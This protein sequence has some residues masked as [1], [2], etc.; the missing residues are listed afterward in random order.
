M[1]L[2]NKLYNLL[3][4]LLFIV[5]CLAIRCKDLHY[6]ILDIK[7][8]NTFAIDLNHNGVIDS[9]EWLV[10]KDLRVVAAGSVSEK[11]EFI[12]NQLALNFAKEYFFNQKV[13]YKNG[14]LLVNGRSY[15]AAF[16]S[17]GYN[18]DLSLEKAKDLLNY[19]RT[20]T[21]YVVNMHNYRYH[22]Y[23]CKH[24]LRAEKFLVFEQSNLPLKSVPC[25][26]CNKEL[27]KKSGGIKKTKKN[28]G[29]K[30]LLTDLTSRLVP[31]KDCSSNI[32][33][34]LLYRINSAKVSI[35]FAIYGYSEVPELER[36]IEA[37]KNR[38]VKI[39][40]V[41]D[42]DSNNKTDYAE[43]E[44]LANLVGSAMNDYHQESVKNKY[45]NSL[46]HNK[47]YIF[48]NSSV[49]MGSAN[50]SGT[51]MSG[52]NS[53]SV[54]VIDSPRV[55]NIY[56]TEFEKMY[57][58]NFHNLKSI[59]QNNKNI[60]VD[61]NVLSVYFSPQDRITKNYIIPLI[62]KSKKSIFVP[63]FLITDKWLADELIAAN[64]RGVEVRV[65]LDALSSNSP[66]SQIHRLR[67]SGVQVK[68]ENYAGKIHSKSIIIDDEIV[69]LGSMNFSMSGQN[70]NDEN[71]VIIKH[72]KM[73]QEYRKFFDYLWEK[74]DERWLSSIP[75]AE[76]VDSIG[77]CSDGIDNNYDGNIDEDDVGCQET[78]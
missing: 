54:L 34:E 27:K 61:E 25:S 66:Y 52:F 78:P 63:A 46:M 39:R 16:N 57:F 19:I 3:A 75:R 4:V 48:D 7:S 51:D 31:T 41:Y 17:A 38:G 18:A 9:D 28:E 71:V 10:L 65:I 11:E 40:M 42:V 2:A 12:L 60:K 49:V 13:R 62:K 72:P 14:D 53:N 30:L 67:A 43:S 22:K 44:R 20:H 35:D 29:V 26:Y 8:S 33:R 21:F 23:G 15:R 45:S 1:K 56:K 74:I 69:V 76:G 37:A 73:A 55:A 50:L 59:T 58:G 64:A 47:F 70:H 77:S 6:T 24:Y 5:L 32:C 36:A 68:V